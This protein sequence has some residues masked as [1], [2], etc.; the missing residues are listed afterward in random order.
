VSDSSSLPIF[1]LSVVLISLSG[2]MMPG[3]VTAVT[4]WNGA[5]RKTAGVLV[6]V[7]HG[8]IEIP[9]I[10]LAY[11]GFA[12]L[13]DNDALHIVL[14][15][16]GGLVLIGMAVIS[17]RN[18]TTVES[19]PASSPR[20]SVAA[21]LVT[22]ATN[23]YFY[24]WWA[25]VGVLLLTKASAFGTTGVVAM[26]ATHWLCDASWLL[27][28][29]FVVFKSKRLWTPTVHRAIFVVCALTLAGF[30]AYFIYSGISLAAGT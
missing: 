4:I 17:F 6:A 29:S 26:G 14:G 28:V 16:L 20:G 19:Q 11:L 18:R 3:P 25:I 23:P 15:I 5:K 1:L 2:V 30:G 21:G 9:I 27:L 13:L 24:A 12:R 10:V 22:T 8:I 7:G